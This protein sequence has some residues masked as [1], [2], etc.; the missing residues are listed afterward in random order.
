MPGMGHRSTYLEEEGHVI[1]KERG[2][3]AQ[4]AGIGRNPAGQ[5]LSLCAVH[6]CW[7]A[8]VCAHPASREVHQVGTKRPRNRSEQML[9]LSLPWCIR[10]VPSIATALLQR[11]PLL[12][13][14][15]A[16]HCCMITVSSLFG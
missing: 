9:R 16:H 5:G 10:S 3:A 11:M 14:G 12:C 15:G 13:A 6:H 4:G 7:P 2:Y 1:P 8:G